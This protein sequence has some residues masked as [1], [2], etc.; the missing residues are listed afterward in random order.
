MGGM[1]AA[2]MATKG[3]YKKA[4]EI[5][6]QYGG[7]NIMDEVQTGFGRLGKTFWG[8]EWHGVT[9]DIITAAKSK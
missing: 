1:G 4:F 3:F 8:F 6:K 2:M 9:P 7:V 5:T